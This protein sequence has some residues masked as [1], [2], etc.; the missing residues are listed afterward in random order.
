MKFKEP[1]MEKEFEHAP[2]L[3]KIIAK[4]I[5]AISKSWGIEPVITRILD[6]YQ[7]SLYQESGV[8][9]DYRAIDFRDEHNGAFL[10]S[11]EQRE[12]LLKQINNMYPRTDGKLSLISHAVPGGVRHFHLQ[13]AAST[14]VHRIP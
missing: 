4:D 6:V 8:H 7:T 14:K 1:H 3:L 12:F 13:I 5:E 11:L 2:I 9:N 10:Y